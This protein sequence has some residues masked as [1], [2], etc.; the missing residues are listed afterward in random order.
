M[1]KSGLES[2]VRQVVKQAAIMVAARE[3]AERILEREQER[4]VG[5]TYE[6]FSTG[7]LAGLYRITDVDVHPYD[8]AITAHGRK[9]TARGLGNQRWNLGTLLL[10]RFRA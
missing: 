3:K 8:G 6:P 4:F 7:K 9:I 5:A 2:V 10:S 1:K